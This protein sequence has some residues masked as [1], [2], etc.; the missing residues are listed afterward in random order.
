MDQNL[1]CRD[2]RAPFIYTEGEQKFFEDRGFKPPSR[3]K[4]C[5]QARK[6]AQSTTEND[7]TNGR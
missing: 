3:C 6:A 7:P 5:R 4:A 2:C 1:T